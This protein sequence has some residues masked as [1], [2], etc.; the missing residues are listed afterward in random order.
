M[1][2]YLELLNINQYIGFNKEYYYD[3]AFPP[4]T[5]NILGTIH[6]KI[7]SIAVVNDL[8]KTPNLK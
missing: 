8:I 2:K 3:L 1:N 5:I 6:K 7:D 4:L